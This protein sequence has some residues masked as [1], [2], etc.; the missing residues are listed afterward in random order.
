MRILQTACHFLRGIESQ[1]FFNGENISDLY[2]ISIEYG[3]REILNK[4]KLKEEEIPNNYLNF[5]IIR[6]L[7]ILMK[8]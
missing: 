6:N 7:L 1:N 5:L 2:N 8:N 3:I 4:E